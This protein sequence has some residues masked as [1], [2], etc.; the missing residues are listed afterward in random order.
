MLTVTRSS[1]RY[2]T[3]VS[4]ASNVSPVLTGLGALSD[5]VLNHRAHHAAANDEA[6]A[7]EVDSSSTS[8][9]QRLSWRASR[10]AGT[11]TS[12]APTNASADH[13]SP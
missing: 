3:R 1:E 11:R 13:S 12:T 5:I 2:G 7:S 9:N 8:T 6:A 4:A 10:Q